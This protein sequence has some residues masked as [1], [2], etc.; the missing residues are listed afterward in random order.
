MTIRSNRDLGDIT[1]LG[2]RGNFRALVPGLLR[3]DRSPRFLGGLVA[4]RLAD[5]RDY[6]LA[7]KKV[8]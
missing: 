1:G 6:L 4:R 7:A 8:G 5:F 3:K 2:L